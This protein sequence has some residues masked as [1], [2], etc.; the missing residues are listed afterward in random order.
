M[1]SL[2]KEVREIIKEIAESTGLSYDLVEDIY[3]HEFEFIADQ[4]RKGIKNNPSTY[5]NILI[6]KLGTFIANEKHINKLKE[7]TG[8]KED[9]QSEDCI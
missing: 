6:K 5:E 4:M 7:V 2:Q 9:K 3:M 1:R 8:A